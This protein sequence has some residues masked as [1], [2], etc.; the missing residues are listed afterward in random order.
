MTGAFPPGGTS[1]KGGQNFVHDP[2]NSGH[3]T[4]K[5]S[6]KLRFMSTSGKDYVVTRAMEL[7]QKKTGVTFKQ[8][9][10]VLRFTNEATG[11]TDKSS[12][13]VRGACVR[14]PSP[15]VVRSTNRSLSFLFLTPA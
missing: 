6:V 10:G 4:V 13:K 14:P 12:L 3:S 9:D 15:L 5:A 7:T 1:G 11:K 8:L 2:R